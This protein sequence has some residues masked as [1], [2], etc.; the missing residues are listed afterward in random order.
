MTDAL[1]QSII[2][3][4][5]S[6]GYMGVFYGALLEEFFY[7]V[8]S[9]LV[10]LTAGAILLS[11]LAISWDLVIK[12]M[13]WIGIPASIGVTLG[14]L[15]YYAL[16]YYG[17][18]PAILKW[19]KWLGITWQS[20][21][22]F[23]SKL[24]RSWWDDVVFTGLRALPILPSVVL[25][26]G[27]G[28]FRLPMRTYLLGSFIGTFIRATVMGFIGSRLGAGV[29]AFSQTIERAQIIGAVFL[30]ITIVIAGYFWWRSRNKKPQ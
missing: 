6:L 3:F 23:N 22:D 5:Q 12:T 4:V 8:P 26:V 2:G 24:T 14:S 28:V 25:S 21:E 17:G 30:V 15:P 10:Q 11:D 18:K 16:G 13:L 1:F 29:S 9:S 7:I 20:V 27:P 19:G